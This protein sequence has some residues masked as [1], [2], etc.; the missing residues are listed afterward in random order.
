M[1]YIVV[2]L[3]PVQQ[4]HQLVSAFSGDDISFAL[5]RLLDLRDFMQKHSQFTSPLLAE[6]FADIS[7]TAA[8]RRTCM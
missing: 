2:K 8:C 7:V 1:S 6:R 3:S 5:S 4:L